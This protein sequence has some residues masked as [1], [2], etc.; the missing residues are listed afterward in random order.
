M[1]EAIVEKLYNEYIANGFIS[2]D[3]V[4]DTLQIEGVPL[5]DVE[6]ICDQLLARG[7]IILE[8]SYDE[9][10]KGEDEPSDIS[11]TDYEAVYEEIVELD[12]GLHD[13]IEYIR[14]I[15]L[16]QRRE[17]QNLLPQAQNGN[18][19][20]RD[21]LFEMYMRVAAKIA[22]HYAKRYELPIADTMQD[23]FCGLQMAIERFEFGKVDNFA[24]YFTFWV[25]QVVLREAKPKKSIVYLPVHVKEKLFLIY[26]IEDLHHCPS[27][28]RTVVCPN[29]IHEIAKSLE[30]SDEE[31]RFL[32][33]LSISPISL[34]ELCDGDD[35]Y[36]SKE[37][38]E[39]AI[40]VVDGVI[41]KVSI[42][43]LRAD[44]RKCL[45]KLTSKEE[46]VIRLRYGLDDGKYRTLEE[47]GSLL[48]VS[49]ERIRQI[50]SKAFRKILR[51]NESGSLFAAIEAN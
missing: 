31:A 28:D 37:Y 19:Y 12:E 6:Y 5:F 24:T 50:E 14:N 38:P 2:E 26:D 27:C 43:E 18:K 9:D 34:D 42:S 21:R 51:S 36:I 13:I 41:E 46:I 16:P 40:N 11:Q 48:S 4:F 35:E 47:I 7:V 30:I 1:H 32:H 39:L 3:K 44:I 23:A 29:L 20:A 22:L 49:R 25:R 45:E 8:E 15:R 10:A 17:W 33:Q